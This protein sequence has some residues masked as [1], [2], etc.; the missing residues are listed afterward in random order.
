M[1]LKVQETG[2][3]SSGPLGRRAAIL[4]PRAFGQSATREYTR[5][6]PVV[7]RGVA[8][9]DN[10]PGTMSETLVFIAKKWRAQGDD[11]RTF[12]GEFVSSLT[13]ECLTYNVLRSMLGV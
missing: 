3:L 1:P 2:C 4:L 5:G 12:V 6:K 13:E 8:D 10:P 7:H 11:F 9:G